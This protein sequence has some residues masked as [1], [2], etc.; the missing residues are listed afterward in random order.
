MTTTFFGAPRSRRLAGQVALVTGG[1]RGIGAAIVRAFH[2]EGARVAFTYRTGLERAEELVH[3]L[4]DVVHLQ[5]DV[6]RT[7]DV[8]D[9]VKSVYGRFGRLDLLV[10]NAGWL[11]QKDFFDID[12]DDFDQSID[13]N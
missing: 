3:D 7:N 13:I 9:A 11:Q 10:N 2:N 8:R 5:L 4:P 6:R 12:D 1:S